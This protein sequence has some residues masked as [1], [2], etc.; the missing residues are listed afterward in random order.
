ML[1]PLPFHIGPAVTDPLCEPTLNLLHL[2]FHIGPAA[3]NLLSQSTLN[4]LPFHTGPDAKNSLCEA[5][6]DL[7]S[8]LP[9]FLVDAVYELLLLL[10]FLYA[11]SHLLVSTKF[12]N[13]IISCDMGSGIGLMKKEFLGVY[14]KFIHSFNATVR[15][16]PVPFWRASRRHSSM[17]GLP[18][19]KVR[20]TQ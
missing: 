9:Y 10:L 11:D 20:N 8:Q 3:I 18:F 15:M 12:F 5:T 4:L 14:F 16:S 1:L 17:K 6:L 2:P 7:L 19:T 13:I